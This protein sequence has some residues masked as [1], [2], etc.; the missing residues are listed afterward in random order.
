[1]PPDR[2][3][4]RGPAAHS[5]GHNAKLGESAGYCEGMATMLQVM[6]RHLKKAQPP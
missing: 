3:A 1:M 6:A 2:L 5:K 4:A